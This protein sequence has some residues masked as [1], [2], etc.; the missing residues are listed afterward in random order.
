[1]ESKV[2]TP[3]EAIRSWLHAQVLVM[4]K[5]QPDCRHASFAEFL[6]AHGR[7][8]RIPPAR[9]DGLNNKTCYANAQRLVGEHPRK[10]IYCEGLAV[11]ARTGSPVDHAWCVSRQGWVL[12]PT[13]DDGLAYFGVPIKLS[14]VLASQGHRTECSIIDNWEHG[15]PIYQLSPRRW[16]A[17]LG[18]V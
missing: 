12:D 6:L 10:L 14:F 3:I 4:Q 18:A 7:E 11:P 17:D 2:D 9:E 1:M 13:W 16:K 15:Y 5:H 8:F